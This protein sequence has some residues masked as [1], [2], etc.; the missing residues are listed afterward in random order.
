LIYTPP[1]WKG[2]AGIFALHRLAN[3][4]GKLGFNVEMEFY[5]LMGFNFSDNE[6]QQKPISFFN[7]EDLYNI[8]L[9]G[10]GKKTKRPIRDYIV[11]YP[12]TVPGN[13]LNAT[14][15]VRYV[16][17]FPEK[18]MIPMV[19][20]EGD[21]ILAYWPQYY[22]NFDFSF[23]ILPENDVLDLSSPI[24]PLLDRRVNCCYTGKGSKV[25]GH[26]DLQGT[27][28]I[29]REWPES[30]DRLYEL[31]GRTQLFFTW[32]PLSSLNFEAVAL[33]ALPVFL[34]FQP[35]FTDV[36]DFSNMLRS[37]VGSYPFAVAIP[38]SKSRS[39][40]S[41]QLYFDDYASQRRA[42]LERYRCISRGGL[43]RAMQFAESVQSY[44][45]R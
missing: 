20:G 10:G 17:N 11:V 23:A 18:N 29:T 12:E 44:F 4:L 3:Y 1:Y 2:S 45:R 36:Y 6:L 38:D 43:M 39:Y 40:N 25:P 8:Q 28:V 13:P 22:P 5:N 34:R 19:A 21:Y 27:T 7:P 15:V 42:A 9:R 31:L 35:Y 41:L 33:G 26:F 14:N 16:M 37:T 24:L 30:K 32:D